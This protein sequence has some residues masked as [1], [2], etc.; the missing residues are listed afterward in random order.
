MQLGRCE[1]KYT[2]IAGSEIN[3]SNKLQ[4]INLNFIWRYDMSRFIYEDDI[5]KAL[6]DKLAA[7]PFGYDVITCDPSTSSKENIPL[8]SPLTAS[9]QS[10]T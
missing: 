8:C 2:K 1:G 5:E 4:F 9:R 6:L 3:Y 7:E 10:S